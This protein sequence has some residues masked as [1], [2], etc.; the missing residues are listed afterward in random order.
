MSDHA[1]D[2]TGM[3]KPWHKFGLWVGIGSV[4][5]ASLFLFS[6]RMTVFSRQVAKA[7][8]VHVEMNP[9][10]QPLV[11]PVITVRPADR[12]PYVGPRQTAMV[13]GDEERRKAL[14]SPIGAYSARGGASGASTA[15][16]IGS[17]P[18]PPPGS[19]DALEASLQPTTMEGTRVA[20]LPNPR[21]LIE[22]GRVLP[23]RQQTRINTTLPG[24]VTAIIPDEIRGETGDT[25]LFDKGAKVFGTIQHGLTNGANVQSVLWQNI[26]TP[27]LYDGRGMP[28]QFRITVNS[29]AS[30]PL[31]ETGLEVDVNR[32]LGIKIGG[33]L[34]ASLLQGGIQ[35]GIAKSQSGTQINLNQFQSGSNTAVEQLLQSWVAIPDVGTRDQGL[36]CSIFIVRDL[37]MRQA[38]RLRQ[39]YKAAK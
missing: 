11:K 27:V 25:V 32:H 19:A 7:D 12:P 37:D 3:L 15:Q 20:E 4:G 35:A 24:A 5:V 33:I 22:Q 8:P 36:A 10:I 26:S 18:R 29:P 38:Y 1:P 14:D 6:G 21:W 30:S 34:G 16:P 13:G 2:E 31:G 9:N 28:H 23:C 17:E 39:T